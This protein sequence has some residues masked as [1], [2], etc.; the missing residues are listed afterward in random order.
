MSISEKTI[1]LFLQEKDLYTGPIDGKLGTKSLQAMIGALAESGVR[2]DG[3]EMRRVLIAVQ[4]L[5]M[6]ESG[7][8]RS[9]VGPVDGYMGPMFANAFEAWQDLQRIAPSWAAARNASKKWPLQRDVESFYG[10]PGTNLVTQRLP[11]DMRLAWNPSTVIKSVQCHKLVAESLEK[12][13]S[14]VRLVYPEALRQRLGLDIYSGGFVIRPMKSSVSKLSMHAYGIAFDFDDAH[15]Q[16]RWTRA[17]ARFARPEYDQ[18]WAAWE[19]EGWISLG[20]E[21]DF[22]FMHVQAARLE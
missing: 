16:Y 13:L 12:V 9:E 15:N 7:V 3:W 8:S 2:P 11:Y 1:Q 10:K 14:E 17:Q 6:I 4:Q 22:D 20:R 19:G 18:W 21:R 5:I